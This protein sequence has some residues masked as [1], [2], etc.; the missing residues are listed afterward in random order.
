[1]NIPP[2]KRKKGLIKKALIFFVPIAISGIIMISLLNIFIFRFS[3]TDYI[4]GNLFGLS[5]G[6][7]LILYLVLKGEHN[8]M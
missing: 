6:F 4:I 8:E 1:M 7:M 2:R 5:F 3:I